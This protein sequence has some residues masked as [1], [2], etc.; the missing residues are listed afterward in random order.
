[1]SV[2]QLHLSEQ[3][4]LSAYSIRVVNNGTLAQLVERQVEILRV[5]GSTPVVSHKCLFSSVRPERSVYIGRGGSSNLSG[6]TRFVSSFFS[7]EKRMNSIAVVAPNA[8]A[9]AFQALGCEFESHLLHKYCALEK[10]SSRSPHKSEIRRF[11]SG[12]RY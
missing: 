12:M 10:W 5:T 2:V 3:A 4:T 8:R 11:E 7:Q 6:D 9:G 1:M